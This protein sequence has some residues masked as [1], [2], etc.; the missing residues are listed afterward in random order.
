MT[1]V[2]YQSETAVRSMVD[3]FLLLMLAGAGDELQGM[4]RGVMEMADLVAI[5][6]ADRANKTR[7]QQARIETQ[8]ALHFFPP[9]PTGWVSRAVTSSPMTGEGI[10]GLW[11][12]M[13]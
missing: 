7:A 12:I 8:N 5:N 6:K 3:F 10:S 13:H 11:Q 4:K 2:S 1:T 9:A